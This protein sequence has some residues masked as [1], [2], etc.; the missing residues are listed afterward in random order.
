MWNDKTLC[1]DICCQTL[2]QEQLSLA[3]PFLHQ[4]Q[5]FQRSGRS[6]SSL[7]SD[8]R[9]NENMRRRRSPE[10]EEVEAV[11][12]PNFHQITD[13]DLKCLCSSADL[14][15]KAA[16]KLWTQ[17]NTTEPIDA[18]IYVWLQI[19]TCISFFTLKKNHFCAIDNKTTRFL[20]RWTQKQQTLFLLSIKFKL[21]QY[22]NLAL[23]QKFCKMIHFNWVGQIKF[24]WQYYYFLNWQPQIH[25][26]LFQLFVCFFRSGS[27]QGYWNEIYYFVDHLAHKFLRCAHTQQP[28]LR[29]ENRNSV[30]WEVL[31]VIFVCLVLSCG[32][33]LLCFQR[34]HRFSWL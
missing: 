20:N 19:N 16:N 10:W 11:L 15:V 1:G 26:W 27:V 25:F 7:H 5:M 24:P 21:G 8:C 23:F 9:I 32:C 14:F 3:E 30:Q 18:S 4:S 6:G 17:R 12:V 34:R 22:N 29:K 2:W 33:L 28:T 31:F 13:I